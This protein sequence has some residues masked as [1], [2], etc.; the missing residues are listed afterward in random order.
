MGGRE[1]GREGEREGGREGGR[2][3]CDEGHT[4]VRSHLTPKRLGDS[5]TKARRRDR[6]G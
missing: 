3:G 5:H 2:E 6:E 4:V 1:G